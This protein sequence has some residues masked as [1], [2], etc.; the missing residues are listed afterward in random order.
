MF[1]ELVENSIE[2]FRLRSRDDLKAAKKIMELIED[3]DKALDYLIIMLV[4]HYLNKHKYSKEN[5]I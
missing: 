4:Y 3:Y 2:K 1:R 5:I